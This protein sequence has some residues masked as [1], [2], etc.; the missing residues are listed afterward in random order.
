MTLS[1]LKLRLKSIKSSQLGIAIMSFFILIGGVYFSTQAHLKGMKP[2][3][4]IGILM[5]VDH[6]A[7]REIVAGF[8]KTLASQYPQA[9]DIKVQNAQGDMNIQRSILQQ[10]IRQSVDIIV[11]IG[12]QATQMA[13]AMVEDQFI[14][15]LAANLSEST[16]LSQK[17][18]NFTGVVDEI[19]PEKQFHLLQNLFP[20]LKKMTL[21]YSNSEKIFPEVQEL[22]ILAKKTGVHLQKLRVQSLPELYTISRL[23]DNESELIFILKDHLIVN[24][25]QT[26]MK[27]AVHLKIPLI[28][29]DEGSVKE[30][31]ACA[32]G[33]KENLIG[34]TGAM[35]AIQR[36]E[37]AGK[38]QVQ[39]IEALSIFY[40]ENSCV[41]QGLDIE[42]LKKMATELNYEVVLTGNEK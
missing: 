17:S 5:P 38:S 14:I 3:I 42:V 25:I 39:K 33:V 27:Q 20:H 30:G 40:N 28:S 21:I 37:K 13:A 2:S 6:A 31:A 16:R 26:L 41:H 15:S 9:V 24:G 32:L 12:T 4:T 1:T 29:S 22:E 35:L 8:K 10:F 36:L 11:P 18:S 7:L 34:E 23:I 19:G